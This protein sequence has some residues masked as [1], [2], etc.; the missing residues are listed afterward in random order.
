MLHLLDETIEAFLRAE[1]PLPA[2]QVDVSFDAPDSEWGAAITKPTVNLFLWDLRVNTAEREAGVELVEEENGGRSWR[3]PKPR[4]DCRYLVTAWTTEVQDEH[5]LLGAVLIAL[6]RNREI[7][8][9]HLQG[10]YAGVVPL[11]TVSAAAADGEGNP[12]LWTA[13]GGKLKPGL[14][15]RI[16]ATVDTNLFQEAGPPVERY[17]I[18]LTDRTGGGRAER[19]ASVGGVAEGASGASVLSP[20]GRATADAEGRFLIRAEEGDEVTVATERPLAAKV[21]AKGA[22]R[23][24]GSAGSAKKRG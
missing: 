13:L 18:G 8:A 17:E 10:D 1:V 14:D 2:R 16:T 20:R 7:A 9:E 19:T 23:V 21:P 15:L 24:T 22:V 4:V 12:D 11:P 6:L 3:P 5:R